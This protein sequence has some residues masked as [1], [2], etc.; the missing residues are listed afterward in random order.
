VAYNRSLIHQ[1][2]DMHPLDQ[3]LPEYKEHVQLKGLSESAEYVHALLEDAVTEVGAK[4]VV[5]MGLSQGCAVGLV[6]LLLW[7][8]EK[9]GGF[10]GMCG[11][12]PLRKNMNEALGEVEGTGDSDDIFAV[13]GNNEEKTK[14]EHA[15]DWLREEIE[16]PFPSTTTSG[17]ISSIC[18][19]PVFLGNGTEDQK[20][21]CEL[22]ALATDFLKDLNINV[23]HEEYPSLGHWYSDDMLRDIVEWLKTKKGWLD[24]ETET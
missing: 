19:T 8:R 17:E 23:M 2:F 1:W 6:S 18:E 13:D 5:L 16:F 7:K 22:G 4:N 20:V 3:Y 24:D 9:L 12:L 15:T 10:V 14:L 11:W 21:P